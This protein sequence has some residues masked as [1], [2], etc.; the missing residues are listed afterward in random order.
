MILQQK[1]NNQLIKASQKGNLDKVKLL[2]EQGADIYTDNDF[3]LKDDKWLEIIKYLIIDCNMNVKKETRQ[4]LQDNN[5]LDIINI[6]N[7]RNLHKKLDS[8]LNNNYKI[9]I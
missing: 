7:T 6:I 2:I 4:Y 3:I 9:K 5:L 8:Q 1:L